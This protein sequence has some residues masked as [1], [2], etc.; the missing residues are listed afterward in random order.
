MILLPAHLA[1]ATSGGGQLCGRGLQLFKRSSSDSDAKATA[2]AVS[3]RKCSTDAQCVGY[4]EG[5]DASTNG[6][7]G[8]KRTATMESGQRRK[9][10]LGEYACI[11]GACRYV[12]KAGEI[13]VNAHDCAA[14]QL[15]R[16]WAMLS[17]ASA[18]GS[19]R[20]VESEELGRLDDDEDDEDLS[21]SWCAPQFCTLESTCGGAWTLP[22]APIDAPL[23]A[24]SS[25][26]N[27][28]GTEISCCRGFLADAQCGL[29]SG[30]VDTCGNG[31]TCVTPSAADGSSAIHERGA[32]SATR[33][34]IVDLR[35]SAR[36]G[37]DTAG[38]MPLGKCISQEPHQQV[39]IGVLLVL[40]G[41]AT[42]N[43]GLNL[44][45]YAFRKREEKAKADALVAGEPVHKSFSA[46][47]SPE[48][49][50][51]RF[52][53]VGNI[54]SHLQQDNGNSSNNG[55][56]R[57]SAGSAAS[58]GHHGVKSTA[59]SVVFPVSSSAN[60]RKGF[61]YGGKNASSSNS[62][63]QI[64]DDDDFVPIKSLSGSNRRPGASASKN[65]GGSGECPSDILAQRPCASEASTHDFMCTSRQTEQVVAPAADEGIFEMP[66]TRL[67]TPLPKTAPDDIQPLC[68]H[69]QIDTQTKARTP[70][71]TPTA[72][73]SL[74]KPKSW[75]RQIKSKLVNGRHAADTPF[76]SPVWAIGL[77][78]FILG[79]VVNFIAL[80]F[81]PQ[82]LVAP[83]GAVSLVTNVIVAPL[84]NN[85]KISLF[86]IGGIVLIIAGCVVVVVFSGIV[87]Q[88]YRLCV[89][90][91]LLKAKPT[92]VYL[93]LI[94]AAIL[95]IYV[96]L[97]TV[98][99]G[100]ERYRLENSQISDEPEAQ[101][102]PAEP[103]S[104]THGATDEA[105]N[106]LTVVPLHQNHC[107]DGQIS[108][109][110]L[111]W[112]EDLWTTLRDADYHHPANASRD[113]DDA[114][115]VNKQ[116]GYGG[117][118]DPGDP[119]QAQHNAS[120]EPGD[121]GVVT[122]QDRAEDEIKDTSAA[123]GTTEN[124]ERQ[125]GA[126]RTARQS[127]ACLQQV[128][129][130]YKKVAAVLFRHPLTPFDKYIQPIRPD[131]RHVKYGL[132][133]AYASLGSLMATLTTL[134][135]KSLINLLSVSLFDH[136]NQFTSFFSWAIFLVTAFT[137]ASQV[138][139]INQ[140]L[141]RYDALLQVP[142][143]YVVW[144]VL[145]IVGGGVYFNE[146]K[147]FTTVKYVLFGVGVAV[148][149][150]GVGLLSHRMKNRS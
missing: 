12:V 22:G 62:Y 19:N 149:F 57:V 71:P 84:L 6:K 33:D 23:G 53:S 70:T 95:S 49:S 96:F 14:F 21:H 59:A 55:Q 126:A 92:V 11:D 26:P 30:S 13:C 10:R 1:T 134:F 128:A 120:F 94:A 112:P 104:E 31:Y 135:A 91:Q 87:Q 119:W 103:G 44:Q 139:W 106:Q 111:S 77:V 20:T 110:A 131:S 35:Q 61:R 4:R 58:L 50:K 86:D 43:V 3:G 72:D 148:I 28:N 108:L 117:R 45:K 15:N 88:D 56:N 83:L 16:R 130:M 102:L 115:T 80:Q 68:S 64:I 5:T 99:K 63:S 2:L 137:A 133:L 121:G 67:G 145:D 118:A 75:Q 42:L 132:P 32:P 97:R 36:N 47:P 65:S 66:T 74:E 79:N 107:Y 60:R 34:M 93:C 24:S 54:H 113:L 140:G 125:S 138:Y 127:G 105:D 114:F 100:A 52:Y 147:W 143:F 82:S 109:S 27:V 142:V 41:G 146:F 8:S 116:G 136:D 101:E 81:A 90:I 18:K 141:L 122:Q 85:E 9:P 40:V 124:E 144:T 129:L 123:V 69:H 7:G 51:V 25:N 89:L 98:E 37:A 17:T 39:W 38:G 48:P 78:I 46:S 29:S 76:S 73:G 150:S